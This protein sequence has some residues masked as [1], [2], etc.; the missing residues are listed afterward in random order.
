MGLEIKQSLKLSQQLVM[1]PQLQQAIKLLQ[2]S[3]LELVE[4]INQEMLENPLLEEADEPSNEA[5]LAVITG[6]PDEPAPEMEALAGPS[7]S[8][9]YATGEVPEAR[10]VAADLEEVSMGDQVKEDFDWE[11]YLGEYSSAPASSEGGMAEDRDAPSFDSVLTRSPSLCEHLLWQLRLSPLDEGQMEIGATIINNLNE[12]GYLQVSLDYLAAGRGVSVPQVEAVLKIIQ[13][14]DPLGVAARDLKECL[15]IQATELYPGH[16]LVFDLLE[17]HLGD[18]ERRNYHAIAKRLSVSLDEVGE[19]LEVIR[20]LDPKPGR[21]VSEDE[22][23]YITPDIYIYKV[24]GEF[25]IVLNEDG[26]PKLR[27]NNFYK[28]SLGSGG[29]V[30]AKEYVQSKLRSAV[31]LIRSIHQR[32]RTIYKVTESIVGFQRDFFDRGIAFLKPLV[33]RDVAEDVGMHESTIS[34]VTTNKYMHTPQGVFELKYFFNS[35]INRVQGGA[36]ASESVKERIRQIVAAEDPAK[37]LSDQTIGDML[38]KENIDIAR[39]TVAKYREMLGILPSS[40]RR[41]ILKPRGRVP[42]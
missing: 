40:R 18:L 13:Q 7:E 20:R 3:R 42:A 9:D 12:D 22:P 16:D 5:E 14:F 15:L 26:L 36:V 34:R 38:Q 28:D 4:T 39:R 41:Q 21:T 30:E 33:L 6:E 17:N 23:Q 19:A 31:W 2:L 29:S 10:D 37:P 11:N 35:G 27:V 8:T 25:V 32:Q 1:T 24:D